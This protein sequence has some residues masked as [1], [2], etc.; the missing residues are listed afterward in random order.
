M[1]GGG[2]NLGWLNGGL[3]GYGIVFD[4]YPQP[5]WNLVSFENP[6]VHIL[7]N[8]GGY[9]SYTP[10]IDLE[11]TGWFD[12][13]VQMDNGHLQVYMTNEG[14]GLPRTLAIDYTVAGYQGFDAHFGFTGATGGLNNNQWVDD[15]PLVLLN[16]YGS[17]KLPA[18]SYQTG[19]PVSVD[20]EVRVNPAVTLG[21]ADVVEQIPPGLGPTDVN[22]P[23]ATVSG[24]QIRWNL[25]GANIKTQIL[26][27]SVTPPEGMT[28]ALAF[29]GTVSFP[30]NSSAILGASAMYPVPTAPRYVEAAIFMDAVVSWSA[31]LTEGATNYKVYRSVN[32]GAWEL[33][34]TTGGTLY[35]DSSLVA[36]EN[37][38]YQVSATNVLGDEGPTSRPTTQATPLTQAEVEQGREIREAEDFNYGS[39]QYP[40]YQGCPAA[41]ESP[42]TTD[43]D[44]QYDYFHPNVGGPDPPIYRTN[45]PLPDG[46]GIETVLDDG[47][48]DVYHTNIG[49]IDIGSWW[50]YTFNVT[51][52]G[53]VDIA[54]RVA[55]PSSSQMAVYWDEVLIG[56]TH[57]FATGT[58]HNMIYVQLEDRVEATA[59]EHVV[60][61][62]SVAGGMNLDK[63]AIAWNAGPPK[64][65][66]I[67][68]DN[69]DSYA[70]TADV[71]SPT[72]GK[73]TRG[74][75]TNSAGSWTL[76]DTEG[77]PLSAE[78]ANIAGMQDKYMISDS[79][80]S[81]AGTILDEEMLSPEVDCADWTKVRLNFNKNYRI[82]DDPNPD[83]TQDAEVDIRS[84]DPVSGWSNWTNLLHLDRTDVDPNATPPELSNPE[85]FDLSAYDGK[86]IQLKFHFFKAEYDYWF[87]FDDVR[88]SGVELPKQIPLPIITLD[89]GNVTVSWDPFEP[90]QYS[91]EYTANL[92]GTWTKIA[93]PFTQTSFTEAMS[94]DKTGY[95][96]ILGQ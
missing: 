79:D 66:T 73:W 37:Y 76:W 27:Y 33:L 61:V 24:G 54:L 90:G 39:G 86:K 43:L 89:A 96:R 60:R 19:V 77:P 57:S 15:L 10:P 2:G 75:T 64:R 71:F 56:R 17:R 95:Y 35:V 6:E 13:E 83:R 65:Q 18:G 68:G 63:I 34:A 72:N 12:V 74:N 84:F 59:G 48:T 31:P 5:N 52:A 42:A 78:S 4:T 21:S 50:R 20:V 38:S 1:G 47:T 49:W 46:I 53:W 80:L 11:N 28:D 9:A 94:A 25:T 58:W 23:G 7:E 92:K 3:R 16:A 82:Y 29:S 88:V 40:G 30:G 14:A 45:D 44:P 69:F 93:G 70:V 22:A 8:T 26:T 51:Q 67:W 36:G 87:A 32:G 85:V 41:S 62:E 91:V 81:G 55:A